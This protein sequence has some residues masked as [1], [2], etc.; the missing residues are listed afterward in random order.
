MR[1]G[2]MLGDLSRVADEARTAEELG[3]DYF[4]SGEHLFFH[5]AMPNALVALAAAAG[6]TS[7]IRL[8]SA[9]SLAPL[10]PAALFAKLA[11]TLDVVSHGRLELGIGAAGEY[12]P[13]FEA[14]GVDPASRF[15]RI[16]ETLDVLALLGAGGAVDFEGEF[17]TLHGVTLAP[18]P[19]QAPIP[20]IWLPGR[21][22]AALRRA[23][24]RADVWIP[25]M[26][27]PEMFGEG[28]EAVRAAAATAGRSPQSVSAAVFAWT[29][30]D[31]D[32]DW[33]RR[34]GID[35]VSRTYNQDFSRLADR[36]LLLGTPKEV[37]ARLR[38]FAEAGADRVVISIA[39]SRSERTRVLQTIAAELLPALADL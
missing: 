26:V 25:Y 20:P 5:G 6:A 15:R 32:G 23:G 31:A 37:T 10:Y 3:F 13:E 16:D 14:V 1:V 8:L 18:T 24:R 34:T 11:V 33:A 36:Y 17:T 21:K 35:S 22:A 39:A 38:Q 2:L 7:R 9:V 30:V 19:V 12:P 29:C 27:T 28:L 4:G